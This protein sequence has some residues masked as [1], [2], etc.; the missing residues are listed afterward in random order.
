MKN[1]KCEDSFQSNFNIYVEI[2]I[3]IEPEYAKKVEIDK[4]EEAI[5]NQS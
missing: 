1:D 3:E 2:W 5:K 4:A